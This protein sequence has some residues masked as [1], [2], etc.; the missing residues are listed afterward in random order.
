MAAK[1]RRSGHHN[2]AYVAVRGSQ[3]PRR[4]FKLTV[5]LRAGYGPH[6][7]IYDL[8]QA[9]RATDQWMIGRIRRGEPF[10]TGMFTRGEILYAPSP[11]HPHRGPV[12]SFSGEAL[13]L[14]ARPHHRT[15]GDALLHR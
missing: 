8:E 14:Q 12:A 2:P 7:R 15:A 9:V 5:G 1:G 3:G 6:G 13:P 11:P 4:E 10:L